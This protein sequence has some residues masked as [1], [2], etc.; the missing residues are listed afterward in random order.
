MRMVVSGGAGWLALAAVLVACGG[1]RNFGSANAGSGGAAD[2]SAGTHTGGAGTSGAV[3]GAAGET[4]TVTTTPC[5]EEGARQCS[6]RTPQY[7]A[8]GFWV[9]EPTCPDL[10]RADG[11]CVCDDGAA[12]CQGNTPQIC[13]G[14]EWIDGSQCEGAA[15]VCTG[16][17]VCAAFVFRPGGL[18]PLGARS[19]EG[20][21]FVLKEQSL[22]A[23]PRLCN[24]RFCLT[25]GV[26]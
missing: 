21:D 17:G 13:E 4:D 18:E 11:R 16:A 6:D 20:P 12:R 1:D 9:S 10:C 7:C 24:A 26:Q 22:S 15:P 23:A 19:A 14:G 8:G 25:G 2:G 5:D 3:T